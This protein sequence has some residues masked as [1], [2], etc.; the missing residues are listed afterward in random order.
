MQG[1]VQSKISPAAGYA[2]EQ[3][4]GTS[5]RIQPYDLNWVFALIR[6][7]EV[8]LETTEGRD[9]APT[10]HKE[11]TIFEKKGGFIVDLIIRN[12]TIVTEK[13][14]FQAD[15]G[16]KDGKIVAIASDLSDV[17]C[18]KVVDATGHSHCTG[19]HAQ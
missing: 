1:H 8:C 4:A 10:G 9:T 17:P 7:T 19:L 3:T 16:V 12:G 14:M 11:H 18:D 15:L 5:G 13:E 6:E 2:A